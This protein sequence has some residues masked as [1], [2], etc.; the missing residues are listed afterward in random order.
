MSKLNEC[1]A[2]S[3]YKS[4]LEVMDSYATTFPLTGIQK[5]L[6]IAF[7]EGKSVVPS[8]DKAK[9]ILDFVLHMG[10]PAES[11]QY[12]LN[13]T[14]SDLPS[15]I[16]PV[17]KDGDIG[18]VAKWGKKLDGKDITSDKIFS[19]L[20]LDGAKDGK[21]VGGNSEKISLIEKE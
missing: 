8:D 19:L 5:Y 2:L 4:L 17:Y 14:F 12:L 18:C 21:W 9:D 11:L 16:R 3:I 20:N 13:R 10:S 15:V 7:E 1:K 6:D